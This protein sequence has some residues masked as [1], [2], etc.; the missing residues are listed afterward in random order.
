MEIIFPLLHERLFNLIPELGKLC[1]R[2]LT[3][4]KRGEISGME[5]TSPFI[6]KRSRDLSRKLAKISLTVHTLFETTL[7]ER[8]E[9][10]RRVN[11][12]P[13]IY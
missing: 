13:L 3:L 2:S 1:R 8:E 5:N 4:L 7:L 11:T 6:L 12:P 9:I 10:S